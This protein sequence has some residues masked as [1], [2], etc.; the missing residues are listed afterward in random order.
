M[1]ISDISLFL[2]PPRQGF[3]LHKDRFI[4][5][6]LSF[7]GSA[8]TEWQ[9]FDSFYSPL[10][11][12]FSLASIFQACHTDEENANYRTRLYQEHSH[13]LMW[14]SLYNALHILNSKYSRPP[15]PQWPTYI[16]SLNSLGSYFKVLYLTEYTS[17]W[18]FS[19]ILTGIL[20]TA[21][22]CGV[23]PLFVLSDLSRWGRD[24]S[25]PQPG[26]CCAPQTFLN[27]IS[28]LWKGPSNIH[29][30]G[31]TQGLWASHLAITHS[32]QHLALS[33]FIFSKLIFHFSG[34]IVNVLPHISQL[35]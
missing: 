31:R 21:C 19:V 27:H 12:H 14:G 26:K 34:Q 18:G 13:C 6:V 15:S 33:Y 32:L 16:L 11:I 20:Y 2:S 9:G 4:L 28:W 30:Y 29:M 3:A 10:D 8:V 5:I 1:H 25:R 35:P 24:C 22:L 23:G 7:R 17:S